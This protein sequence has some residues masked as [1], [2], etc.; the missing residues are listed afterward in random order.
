[1]GACYQM[2]VQTQ[3]FVLGTNGNT[4]TVQTVLSTNFKKQQVVVPTIVDNDFYFAVTREITVRAPLPRKFSYIVMDNGKW[5]YITPYDGCLLRF[6]ESK[7]EDNLLKHTFVM[8]DLEY[9]QVIY[10]YTPKDTPILPKLTRGDRLVGRAEFIPEVTYS[11][12][13]MLDVRRVENVKV[14]FSPAEEPLGDPCLDAFVSFLKEPTDMSQKDFHTKMGVK[15]DR[16]SIADATSH[17]LE[18]VN[19]YIEQQKEGVERSE[20]TSQALKEDPYRVEFNSKTL[21]GKPVL[22]YLCGQLARG[23][24][25][26]VAELERFG[27]DFE[28]GYYQNQLNTIGPEP[29]TLI[30]IRI[31]VYRVMTEFR[32]AYIT[33]TDLCFDIRDYS[34]CYLVTQLYGSVYSRWRSPHPTLVW[35][36][37]KTGSQYILQRN[38]F[39]ELNNYMDHNLDIDRFVLADG[40]ELTLVPQ[41]EEDAYSGIFT[42]TAPPEGDRWETFL[43]TT[44]GRYQRY[45]SLA[46]LNVIRLEFFNVRLVAKACLYNHPVNFFEEKLFEEKLATTRADNILL[47]KTCQQALIDFNETYWIKNNSWDKMADMTPYMMADIMV[48]TFLQGGY[49]TNDE[50]DF[51]LDQ[52]FELLNYY[53]YDEQLERFKKYTKVV[54]PSEKEVVIT[55]FVWT[56]FVETFRH[57][58]QTCQEK[59][60]IFYRFV[61]D[62]LYAYKFVTVAT[63]VGSHAMV[64]MLYCENRS[65]PQTCVLNV[66]AEHDPDYGVDALRARSARAEM[67]LI[68]LHKSISAGLCIIHTFLC[69]EIYL[70]GAPKWQSM[71][72]TGMVTCKLVLYRWLL[73]NKFGDLFGMDFFD[74]MPSV[75]M[76]V[77]CVKRRERYKDGEYNGVRHGIDMH[78]AIMRRTAD[79]SVWSEE[80]MAEN[81]EAFE[82]ITGMTMSRKSETEGKSQVET[83]GVL[84]AGTPIDLPGALVE[85]V[86]PK[87]FDRLVEL[88]LET[89]DFDR[90]VKSESSPGGSGESKSSYVFREPD[91]AGLSVVG[92]GLTQK[93]QS[94]PGRSLTQKRQSPYVYGEKRY[95]PKTPHQPGLLVQGRSL[96]QKKQDDPKTPKRPKGARL[97][98][99]VRLRL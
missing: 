85:T 13:R 20:I 59:D 79:Y 91:H 43:R 78:G 19:T 41:R 69:A 16:E 56:D 50:D 66:N 73:R 62:T 63:P 17:L 14:R 74:P 46:L 93:R 3:Y 87:D 68:P 61:E 22:D 31:A 10:L 96:T 37:R 39:D 82:G 12:T 34:E 24:I 18:Q 5:D 95:D 47:L 86:L 15:S 9:A 30:L 2:S 40:S 98:G 35:R 75:P 65:E 94:V 58:Y 64:V 55:D 29:S 83:H 25:C 92:R 52:L 36:Y 26:A 11:L 42:S 80:F 44:Y 84:E 67:K 88:I 33:R 48:R 27:G 32:N 23:N 57:A 99:F 4:M 71:G 6:I 60:G 70:M 21:K 38:T 76:N 51:V 49:V 97:Q 90:L 89:K 7:Q 45:I 72:C 8:E 81:A 28:M 1:M 77:S 54:L 53:T